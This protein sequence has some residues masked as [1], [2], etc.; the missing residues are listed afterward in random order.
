MLHERPE[1][2]FESRRRSAQL[3]A[4]QYLGMQLTQQSCRLSP[5]VDLG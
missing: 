3:P 4:R 2:N 1:N 5:D